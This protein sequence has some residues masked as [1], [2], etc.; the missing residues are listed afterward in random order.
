LSTDVKV[1]PCG[2]NGRNEQA[3]TARYWVETRKGPS[4]TEAGP[5]SKGF[6]V[7]F[8][9]VSSHFIRPWRATPPL[10]PSRGSANA[11]NTRCSCSASIPEPFTRLVS[12]RL[13]DLDARRFFQIALSR[14]KDAGRPESEE[15]TPTVTVGPVRPAVAGRVYSSFM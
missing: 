5:V 10:P 11:R 15:E 1:F 6:F 13:L 14:Q 8:H 3:L 9:P 2:K 7:S 4:R 12:R